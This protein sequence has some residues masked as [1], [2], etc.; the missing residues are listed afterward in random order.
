MFPVAQIKTTKHQEPTAITES[1]E[2]S[3]GVVRWLAEN[4]L[5]LCLTILMKMFIAA[6]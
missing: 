1:D 2:L 5:I 3:D 6:S 4:M